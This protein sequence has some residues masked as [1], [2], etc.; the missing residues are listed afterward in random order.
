MYKCYAS[1]A[2]GIEGILATEIR[3]LGLTGVMA[4][5]ARVYF[6]ADE[7]GV[8]LANIFLRTADRVY[9]VLGE[10][11][12]R[13]FDEL[14][15]NIT[16]IDFASFIPSDAKLPVNANAVRSELMSVR[17]I[18]AVS[19]KAVVKAMQRKYKLGTLPENG[20]V[21]GLFVNLYKDVATVALNTSGAGLNRRGYRL[22][23]AE[24]PLKETLAAALILIS[25]W[26]SRD[27]YD[28]MCGSGTIAIEAA[29][30]ASNMAPGIHRQFDAQNYSNSF[31]KAFADVREHAGA[32]QTTPEMRICAGDIDSKNIKLATGH[33]RNMGLDGAIDFYVGDATEF[34]QPE[35][36]A[37]I[38]TNPPYAVRL[39]EKEEVE[40]LYKNMGK[41]FLQLQDTVFF[42]LTASDRFEK[43]FGRKADKKRKL[44]NGNLR[45]TYYQYFRKR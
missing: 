38:I 6:E 30:I 9:I 4:Q 36:P 17:D 15:Q 33:A 25:R 21:F 29:M 19:K 27:F 16:N 11:S 40:R 42:V 34:R 22:K 13:S 8:A 45:C 5:D 32:R 31:R 12:V 1:C 23:N 44:Y 43:D 10:F 18:Q 20:G 14:F 7:Y 28:P 41:V 39:G 35:K 2:F 37:T 3:E 26:H 24:A